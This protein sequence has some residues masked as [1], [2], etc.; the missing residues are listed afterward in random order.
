MKLEHSTGHQACSAGYAVRAT[1]AKFGLHAA[2]VKFSTQYEECRN[3]DLATQKAGCRGRKAFKLYYVI[4]RHGP[5]RLYKR[6]R[7]I[8]SVLIGIFRVVQ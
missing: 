4:L 6:H 2:N 7:V 5:V 3:K 8:E 1:W